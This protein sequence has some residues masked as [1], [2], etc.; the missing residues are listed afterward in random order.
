MD[1]SLPSSDITHGGVLLNLTSAGRTQGLLEVVEDICGIFI[2]FFKQADLRIDDLL[3]T[4]ASNHF[5]ISPLKQEVRFYVVD[6][7]LDLFFMSLGD[8]AAK[9]CRRTT[10]NTSLV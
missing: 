8:I 9:Y 6:F 7:R 5:H 1:Q 10:N 3:M 2:L 4:P